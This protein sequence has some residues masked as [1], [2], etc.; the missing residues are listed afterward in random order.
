MKSSRHY[1]AQLAY[2]SRQDVSA[3]PA[4]LEQVR[5]DFITAK[6]AEHI[7]SVMS[8]AQPFTDEQLKTLTDAL[9]GHQGVA[10]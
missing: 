7:Q 10:I 5:G 1:R 6:L 3:P 9:H 8:D 2:L 4:Q